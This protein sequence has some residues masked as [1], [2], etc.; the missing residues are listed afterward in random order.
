MTYWGGSNSNYPY[1]CACGVTGTCA[2]MAYGCNCDKN[3][4]ESR[5]DMQLRFGD[6]SGSSGQRGYHTLGKLI[7]QYPLI[8]SGQVS[9]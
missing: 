7:S 6:N 2:D 4:H 1:K 3:D 8:R 5:E 9:G